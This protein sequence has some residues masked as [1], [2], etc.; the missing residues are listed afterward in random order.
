VCIWYLNCIWEFDLTGV[1]NLACTL[2][3]LV[4]CSSLFTSLAQ[5]LTKLAWFILNRIYP[6]SG[7]FVV[8]D[9]CRPEAFPNDSKLVGIDIASTLVSLVTSYIVQSQSDDK[10]FCTGITG[11]SPRDAWLAGLWVGFLP[12]HRTVVL[13]LGR[14]LQ[15]AWSLDCSSPGVDWNSLEYKPSKLILPRSPCMRSVALHLWSR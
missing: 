7:P 15:V 1:S 5:G 10:G 14:F 2:H 13:S 8:L 9:I 12:G 3:L 4:K 6:Q 11:L